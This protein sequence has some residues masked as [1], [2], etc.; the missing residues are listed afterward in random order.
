[1]SAPDGASGG[2]AAMMLWVSAFLEAQAAEPPFVAATASFSSEP[3]A[4]ITRDAPSNGASSIAASPTPPAAAV[5]RTVSPSRRRA[6]W[7]RARWAVP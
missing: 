4:G 2:P 7:A 1:M 5:T 6:R 3:H